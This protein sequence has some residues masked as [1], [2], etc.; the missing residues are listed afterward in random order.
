MH[1]DVLVVGGGLAGCAL[2]YFLAL[3]GVDVVVVE[4]FD[5]N[6]LASGS[7]AG[8]LHCQI[9]NH[10][11]IVNGEDWAKGFAPALRLMRQSI[12]MWSD[13]GT[14]LGADLEF[15]LPGGLLVAETDRQMRD[16]ER[17]ARIER[18]HG[19]TVEILSRDE[20]RT[21]AP[22]V[23]DHLIGGAYCPDE[24]NAN[25]LRATPAFARAA[26]RNGA[27]IFP[28]TRL[29]SI[30]TTRDGFCAKTSMGDVTARRVV[31]SAGADAGRVA[32]MVGVDLDIE[33]YP[34]QVNVTER[35][36]P[37]VEH[38]LYFAGDRLTLKQVKNGGFLI[39]GGWPSRIDPMSG[40]LTIDPDSLR[41]N[42][43]AAVSV[44]PPLRDVRLLRIWPAIVN[45][46]R[47]WRPILGEVPG[48][49]GFYMNM[50]PWMGF[51]AGPMAARIVADLV[52]GRKTA[53]DIKGISTLH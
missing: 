6:S 28:R 7:N 38:L 4:R 17:K 14:E 51:T 34:I 40:R 35:A 52:L 3:E 9:P 43:R 48:V 42:L 23:S 26:T 49:R 27:R 25:P 21:R 37:L 32:A 46:T 53:M 31:N 50:F 30:E 33:G 44:V 41:R 16:I 22:Y 19:I 24:G 11:F 10:E 8:S 15:A 29:D 18:D 1:T 39:G 45:G 20:L 47:D 36:A 5:L 2:A 13:L 12:H